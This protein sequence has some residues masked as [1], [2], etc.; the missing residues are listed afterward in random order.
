M[1]AEETLGSDGESIVL[2]R[3]CPRWSGGP[4]PMH[5]SVPS[6]LRWWRR[7]RCR[8]Q[9]RPGRSHFRRHHQASRRPRAGRISTCRSFQPGSSEMDLRLRRKSRGLRLQRYLL[10]SCSMSHWQPTRCQ[11]PREKREGSRR[12]RLRWVDS[13]PCRCLHGP[14][15]RVALSSSMWGSAA[16]DEHEG[17]SGRGSVQPPRYK[18]GSWNV[19]SPSPSEAC[20]GL[21]SAR[22]R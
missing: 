20:S 22:R 9:L 17:P 15:G 11:G 5:C 10:A 2:W 19:R 6:G 14:P 21:S 16:H 8:L 18:R 12:H 7:D 3:L 4:I 13:T 1:L